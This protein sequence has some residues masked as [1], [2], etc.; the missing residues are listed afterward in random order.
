[1][2]HSDVTI[3]TPRMYRPIAAMFCSHLWHEVE[4]RDPKSVKSTSITIQYRDVECTKCG[5]RTRL[6]AQEYI[7]HAVK[8]RRIAS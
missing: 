7:S 1:M 4:N 6:T 5:K 8:T 3:T 2:Y